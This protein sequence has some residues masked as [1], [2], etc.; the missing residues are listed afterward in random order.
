MSENV[1]NDTSSRPKT[2][3]RLSFGDVEVLEFPIALGDNPQVS[4][5]CPISMDWQSEKRSVV[6]L[7]F[8]ESYLRSKSEPSFTKKS[9]TGSKRESQFKLS[10][11]DRAERCVTVL[12]QRRGSRF[13][14]ND[15]SDDSDRFL[16]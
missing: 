15:G 16:T 2:E 12:W 13:T 1:P 6:K 7:N 10:V 5:G 14:H 4:E 3:K 11:M 9:G 8:Y